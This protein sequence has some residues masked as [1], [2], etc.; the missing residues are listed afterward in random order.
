MFEQSIN[1]HTS[2]RDRRSVGGMNK[3]RNAFLDWIIQSYKT[4]DG[5]DEH[6]L[7]KKKEEVKGGADQRKEAR[8]E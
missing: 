7:E 4:V 6:K 1:S 5:T 3:W 8:V 2:S